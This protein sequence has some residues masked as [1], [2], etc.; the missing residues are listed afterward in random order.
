MEEKRKWGDALVAQPGN[1]TC[2][3]GVGDIG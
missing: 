2:D 3:S 1:A